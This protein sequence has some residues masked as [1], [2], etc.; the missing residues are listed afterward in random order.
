MDDWNR[1]Q[2]SLPCGLSY[3]GQG[4]QGYLGDSLAVPER[5]RI[6]ISQQDYIQVTFRA[7]GIYMSISGSGRGLGLYV[8]SV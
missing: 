5:S 4:V 6:S 2:P 7:G 3:K 8:I 1:C